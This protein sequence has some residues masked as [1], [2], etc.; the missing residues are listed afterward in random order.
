MS[1]VKMK[2][3]RLIIMNNFLSK[4]MQIQIQNKGTQLNKDECEYITKLV[5]KTIEENM[6]KNSLKIL[7]RIKRNSENKSESMISNSI[8]GKRDLSK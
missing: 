6:N 1:K 2:E 5:K 8:L 7:H 4:K 3:N